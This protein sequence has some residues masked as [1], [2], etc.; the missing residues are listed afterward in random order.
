MRFIEDCF[1]SNLPTT[2]QGS[3]EV[4]FQRWFHFKEAY[5]PSLVIS[6]IKDLG[7]EKGHVLDPFGGSGT[8]A[9]TARLLGMS[10]TTIEVNPFLADIIKTKTVNYKLQDLR[11]DQLLLLEKIRGIKPS[12]ISSFKH[13]P[14]VEM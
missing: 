14:P 11:A 1:A 12:L 3:Q 6:V 5:S 2:N 8:T 9:L 4:P 10:A 7:I 13:L